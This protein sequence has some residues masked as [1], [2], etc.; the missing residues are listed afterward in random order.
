MTVWFVVSTHLHAQRTEEGSK[1]M[2]RLQELWDLD[3]PEDATSPNFYPAPAD[4]HPE[5]RL[6]HR[7]RRS[8]GVSQAGRARTFPD[9]I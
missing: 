4:S 5:A 2:G 3:M 6:P 9:C 7:P 1:S 8:V